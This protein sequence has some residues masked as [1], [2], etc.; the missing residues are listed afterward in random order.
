ME[1]IQNPAL[2]PEWWARKSREGIEIKPS[3]ISP[4]YVWK[5]YQYH[6]KHHNHH[7]LDRHTLH[8]LW[9]PIG[10]NGDRLLN[11]PGTVSNVAYVFDMV[12]RIVMKEMQMPKT[13][14]EQ[15]WK[16]FTAGE[17]IVVRHLYNTVMGQMDRIVMMDSSDVPLLILGTATESAVLDIIDFVHLSTTAPTDHLVGIPTVSTSVPDAVPQHRYLQ[18]QNTY[19]SSSYDEMPPE[20]G[21]GARRAIAQGL[22]LD[23]YE[24]SIIRDGNIF[25]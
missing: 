25:F 19:G 10:S 5:H 7:H 1:K 3:P 21:N 20:M 12:L 22:P 2:D 4:T 17:S 8:P 18:T 24:A 16:Y 13:W 9:V 23:S 14:H 11:D 15:M 6:D